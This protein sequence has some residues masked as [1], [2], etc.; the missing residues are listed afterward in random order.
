MTSPM[1]RSGR[2]L[3]PQD[4]A[5]DYVNTLAIS[6]LGIEGLSLRA[7][8]GNSINRSLLGLRHP[9][10]R[11]M[12]ELLADRRTSAAGELALHCH[13]PWIP[14]AISSRYSLEEKHGVANDLSD[15]AIAEIGAVSM[16]WASTI[17]IDAEQ[18]GLGIA[19]VL[20]RHR[21]GATHEH[22]Y[23]TP[24][25]EDWWAPVS[26]A[27]PYRIFG[28]A[29]RMTD[30][31]N[32]NSVTLITKLESVAFAAVSR[33]GSA[34]RA[35]MLT[36]KYEAEREAVEAAIEDN[37]ALLLDTGSRV[38]RGTTPGNLGF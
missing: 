2:D 4:R 22:G 15:D 35:E 10:Q 33:P 8:A 7:P 29:D 31:R 13:V 16:L 23:L 12:D 27:Y 37:Q 20:S 18:H 9:A 24:V 25:P 26:T 11:G 30:R 34:F 14:S 3:P 21:D 32:T 28:I 17:L 6:V 19:R 38:S 1:S 5:L 36:S